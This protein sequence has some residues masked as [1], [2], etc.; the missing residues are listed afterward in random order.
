MPT[1]GLSLV[2]F[3]DQQQAINHLR[4]TCIPTPPTVADAVLIGE[5]QNATAALGAPVQN[6]GNPGLRPIQMNEPKI[7]A[8]L[9]GIYGPSV[10]AFLGQGASF[11]MVE[12]EPLLAFQFVVDLDHSDRRCGTLSRP[13][14]LPELFDLC[15]PNSPPTDTLHTSLQGQSMIIKSR[16]LNL[17][18]INQGPIPVPPGF[19]ATVG[20]QFA[21]T[22][23]FVHVVRFDGR[24][25][26]HNGYHRVLGAKRAGADEV[27]CLFR[28]V[29]S[30]QEVGISDDGIAT[31]ALPIFATANPPTMA[32]FTQGRAR[33][34]S[35]RAAMRILQINWSQHV[36]YDE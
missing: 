26:L 24:C 1:R 17:V 23:P 19:P 21:W 31:F 3:M 13:P 16:S 2:G 22:F 7:K 32:H 35:L 4:N 33:D 5:W 14:I 8:L 36:L 28:D 12:I 34:V 25:Y 9:G 15:L 10:A 29:Q 20:I 11:Q 6:A 18:M 27:P 30:H